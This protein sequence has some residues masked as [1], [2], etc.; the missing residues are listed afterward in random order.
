M[1]ADGLF[2]SARIMEMEHSTKKTCFCFVLMIFFR[3]FVT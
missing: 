3:T 2:L 1:V